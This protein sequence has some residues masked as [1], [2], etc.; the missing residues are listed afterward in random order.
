MKRFWHTVLQPILDIVQPGTVLEIG[1]DTGINTKNVLDYCSSRDCKLISIDPRPLFDVEA[2]KTQYGEKFSLIENLSLNVISTLNNIDVVFEDGDHNWYTVYN[3]LKEIEARFGEKF[4]VVVF[5][6][7]AWPYGR[8]DMYYNPSTIPDAYIQPITKRGLKY[9]ESGLLER[10]GMN[11]HLDNALQEGGERNGVLTAIEDFLAES[12][13]DLNTQSFSALNGLTVLY[14]KRMVQLES[15]LE[16]A[17]LQTQITSL[18]EEQRLL[19]DDQWRARTQQLTNELEG[20]RTAYGQIRASLEYKDHVPLEK[21]N[22]QIDTIIGDHNSASKHL[23][24]IKHA[25]VTPLV[26]ALDE[27]TIELEQANKLLNQRA[28]TLLANVKTQERRVSEL[29]S[30]GVLNR[31]KSLI[32]RLSV[33]LKLDTQLHHAILRTRF[34][35]TVIRKSGWRAAGS[36]IVDRLSSLRFR[37]KQS[38]TSGKIESK[39]EPLRYSREQIIKICRDR[40]LDRLPEGSYF[41]IIIL[42]R[43]GEEHLPRLLKALT[44]TLKDVKFEVILVDNGSTDD[45]LGIANQYR[46]ALSL[47]VIENTENH[48]FSQANNQGGSIAKGN[49]LVFLNNDI[50]PLHGWLH[51]LYKTHS[52]IPDTGIVGSQLIYPFIESE[53]LK[54]RIQ[55]AGITFSLEQIPR[56]ESTS[57]LRPYNMH[58]GLNPVLDFPDTQPQERACVTAACVLMSKGDYD[59]ISGF[60]ENYVYGYEDIDICLKLSQKNL[61]SIYCPSSVLFHHES[62]TQKKQD[63]LVVSKRRLS[64]IHHLKQQWFSTLLPLYFSEKLSGHSGQFSGHPMK[65]AFAVTEAG[66]DV[67][68]GDYFTALELAIEFN[69]LGWDVMY[70]CRK[71]HTWYNVGPDVDLLISMLDSYDLTKM[72]SGRKRPVT[73]AWARNWFERWATNPSIQDFTFVFSSSETSR[74]YLEEKTERDI[75]LLPIATNPNRFPLSK[76]ENPNYSCDYCFTGSYWFDDREIVSLLDPTDHPDFTFKMFGENW[77]KVDKFSDYHAGFV[78]YENLPEIYA[79]T[80]IV[81]DDANRVTKPFGAVNSRVF[82]AI[83]AGCL[84]LTNGAIGASETFEGK[85]PIFKNKAE[86]DSLL[87]HYLNDESARRKKVNE[88]REFVL[89]SHT[90]KHRAS[91]V[92]STLRQHFDAPFRIA[93]KVPAPR[94]NIAHEWGDYH[95]AMGLRKQLIKLGFQVSIQLLPEWYNA[96]A[97]AADLAIVFRGLSRFTPIPGQLAYMWNI[98]HPDK[99]SLE[100]YASFDRL[101]IASDFWADEIRS[102][103]ERPV[104]SLH[105]CTDPDVFQPEYD[106]RCAH[107]LLFVGNSR[108]VRRKIVGDALDSGLEPAVYGSNWEGFIDEKFIKDEHINND[109][110]NKYY[111]SAKVLLNDHWDSMRKKGFISNR[112]YDALAAKSCIVTDKVIGLEEVVGNSVFSYDSREELA[113]TIESIMKDEGEQ[114][115]KIEAGHKLVCENHGFRNRAETFAEYFEGDQADRFQPR[116]KGLTSDRCV[117]IL[118]RKNQSR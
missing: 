103:I 55:H 50:E 62:S 64:N 42:N 81:I 105:Q 6:D 98:S 47:T 101:F 111:S 36:L 49:Y 27:K 66:A 37:S 41:S 91:V 14:P 110:L 117:R 34:L 54:G 68:A 59:S 57:F 93:L 88:L 21:I 31:L 74:K 107:E 87:N 11:I 104:H 4:P 29:E 19:A 5:H 32:V 1:A 75:L 30:R 22:K 45:S 92:K 86:L 112:I 97:Q 77:D 89:R 106:E 10:N 67:S 80:K 100:E 43:D 71:D 116:S 83:S 63:A 79:S 44:E 108:N 20:F 9:G 35:G 28:Q 109:Q 73:I 25:P 69:R 39:I 82:D 23:G 61:R 95:M 114:R 48:S 15:F 99:V 18:V 52:Q 51:E 113:S 16:S 12:T 118:G 53:P 78:A 38:D 76:A 13:V 17:S 46:E 90:Y 94:W 40:K 56:E 24:A 96:E 3:E 60:D 2:Y 115:T 102:K 33:A 70:L 85:L 84:V 26:L 8:R 65:V 58:V 7:T 72:H